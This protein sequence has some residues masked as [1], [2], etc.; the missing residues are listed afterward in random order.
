MKSIRSRLADW[1]K[2]KWVPGRQESCEYSK[3][4]IWKTLLMGSLGS[5]CYLI[6]YPPNAVLPDHKDPVDGFNHY[7]LNVELYGSG[8]FRCDGNVKRFWRFVWFRP[9]VHTHG[10]TNGNDD[11]LVLSLGFARKKKQ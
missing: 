1:F 2:S 3:M 4:E 11:R 9:D 5:D 6:H 10:M 8:E 7:R